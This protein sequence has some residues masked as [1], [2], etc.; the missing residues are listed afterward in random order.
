MLFCSRNNHN[1][2]DSSALEHIH[3]EGLSTEFELLKGCIFIEAC[4]LS[5]GLLCFDCIAAYDRRLTD[6]NSLCT[7]CPHIVVPLIIFSTSVIGKLSS[8]NCRMDNR[9]V[10]V[11]PK[12]RATIISSTRT[13]LEQ[14]IDKICCGC[15]SN[16]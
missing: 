3:F 10:L 13:Q 14:G 5:L 7:S 11:G 9:C 15:V 6:V 4:L 1:H 12:L 8:K 16:A 2:G